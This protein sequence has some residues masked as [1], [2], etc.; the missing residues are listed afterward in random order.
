VNDSIRHAVSLREGAL[1]RIRDGSG[2]RVHAQRGQIWIT[3]EGD[4]RDAV[5]NEGESLQLEKDG[6]TLIQALSPA[7]VAML[8]PRNRDAAEPN[9]TFSLDPVTQKAA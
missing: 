6:L 4:V 1:L 5:L 8:A 9:G 2:L 7:T 3:Q